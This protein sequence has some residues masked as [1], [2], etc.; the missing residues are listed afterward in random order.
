MPGAGYGVMAM[1]SGWIPTL[2]ARPVLVATRI[3]VTMLAPMSA[4]W[5]VWPF[6]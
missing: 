4:T 3:G 2:I 5:A 6:G 1:S